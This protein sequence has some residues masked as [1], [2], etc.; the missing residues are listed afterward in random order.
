MSCYSPRKA[1]PIGLTENNKTKYKICSY[2]VDKIIVKLDNSLYPCTSEVTHPQSKREI[3]EF[4]KIP[5]GRCIGCRLDYSRSW[6]DRCL[7]EAQYHK[8]N[9]FLTLTYNDDNLR[10][11]DP[12]GNFYATLCKSDMQKFFKSLRKELKKRNDDRQQSSVSCDSDSGDDFR[13]FGCGEYG[14]E[15]YRPH[16]HV[17][18]FGLEIPDLKFYKKTSQGF[19]LY[20]SEWLND[21]WKRGYVVVGELSWSTVAYTARYS[22]EKLYGEEAHVYEDAKVVPPYSMMSLKPAI[23]KKYFEEHKDSIFDFQQIWVSTDDGA[24]EIRPPR[25][26]FK[27]LERES[28]D[29]VHEMMIRRR[30]KS[31]IMEEL[32]NE[33][34]DLDYLDML[35]VEEF[36]KI[37]KTKILKRRE[38]KYAKKDESQNRSK[39]ISE[40]SNDFEKD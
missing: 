28:P 16:Y 7:L 37:E 9:Y 12:C 23:G 4:V 30:E 11:V 21:I 27:L 38:Y 39:S 15:T 22:T 6:A 5:C 17:I 25:Y 32:R 3:T 33:S 13:Y 1:F 20:T 19:N 31:Q 2:E 14:T 18:A 24:K 29:L 34:T 40:H 10:R 26:F 36:N 8:H 35:A